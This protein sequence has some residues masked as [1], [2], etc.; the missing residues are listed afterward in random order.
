MEESRRIGKLAILALAVAISSWFY[1]YVQTPKPKICGSPGGPPVT[2]TRIRLRD[3]R[4]LAYLESGV[5]KKDAKVKIVYSHG[6]TGSRLD[7]IGAST[8]V[9]EEFGVYMVAYDRAGHG[10]SDPNTER[11]LKNEALD[12]EELADALELGPKFYFMGFS[13]GN[14][15][16]WASL[17]YM[18][19]RLAGAVL[20]APVINYYWPGFP[21]NLSAEAYYKQHTGDKW[22]MRVAYYAPWLLNWWIKQPWLPASTAL[23]GT[24]FMP[25]RLDAKIYKKGTGSFGERRRISTQQGDH[26]SLHRDMIVMFGKW[27]FDPMDLP[28]PDFP[29]H[30]WH[31]DEDG[32]VPVTLQRYIC[33]RLNW[34]NYHELSTTGHILHAV[35]GFGD[36]V[37]RALLPQT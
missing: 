7:T 12:V 29:V 36:L 25:N 16:V 23:K 15:A 35:P 6:F 19:H 37:L 10:E 14:Y 30:L 20:M 26:E 4:F 22:A 5:P 13:L 31:G 32:L 34:I 2:A 33:S 27:D 8:V 24:T 1:I 3:G 18:P 28:S 9:I 17:K 21:K 11:S